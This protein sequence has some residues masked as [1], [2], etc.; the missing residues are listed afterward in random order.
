MPHILHVLQNLYDIVCKKYYYKPLVLLLY[1]VIIL[2]STLSPPPL[3]FLYG[4]CTR[5]HTVKITIPTV[6]ISD[7]K[8]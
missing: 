6:S 3:D 8:A 1:F 2:L 7:K 5:N 4:D